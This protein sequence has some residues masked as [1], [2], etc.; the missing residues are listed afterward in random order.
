MK[1]LFALCTLIFALHAQSAEMTAREHMSIHTSNSRPSAQLQA[2]QE[3]HR[4][5]KVDEKQLEQLVQKET[6]EEITSK[7]LTH[8]GEILY[9]DVYTANYRLEVNALDG[10]FLKKEK[11]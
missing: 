11:K 10:A 6:G 1:I 9:Y 3:M 4:I 5:H 8:R 7:K 2:K